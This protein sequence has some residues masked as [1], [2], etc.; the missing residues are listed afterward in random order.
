[1]TDKPRHHEHVHVPLSDAMTMRY[2]PIRIYPDRI[3]ADVIDPD[4][5]D[6]FDPECRERG[7]GERES[8]FA[9]CPICRPDAKPWRS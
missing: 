9:V 5:H 6:V 8:E 4:L 3:E 1:M 2:G 7:R